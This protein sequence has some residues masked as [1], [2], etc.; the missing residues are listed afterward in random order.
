MTTSF[1]RG[2]WIFAAFWLAACGASAPGSAQTQPPKASRAAGDGLEAAFL[3]K[4]RV[5]E[6][7]LADG[8][9]Y[10]LK[11]KA[12]GT[13]PD[14]VAS[15]KGGLAVEG[16]R[17]AHF[18]VAA[19]LVAEGQERE[20]LLDQ[21][22]KAFEWGFQQAGEDGSFPTERGGTTKKQNSLHPK[23]VFIEAAA[24]SLLLLQ[25]SSIDSR[26]RDRVKALTPAL[27]K[28]A[29]WLAD[30]PD[31][32]AFFQ[33]NRN[34]NQLMVVASA[35]QQ[36]AI[37]TKNPELA[38]KAKALMEKV[39]ARQTA[40]GVFPE[41]GGFDSNY[42][43]VSLDLLGHYY[44]TLEPSDWRNT[45]E[46]ALRKGAE[47][48]VQTVDPATGAINDA[49]NTRTVACGSPVSG[50]GPKGKDIDIVPLRL[51]YL[52]FLLNDEARLSQLAERV[53]GQGQSFSHDDKCPAEKRAKA[54]NSAAE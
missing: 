50:D 54:G 45:V 49:A 30:S 32:V 17:R 44:A 4:P 42:Q 37:V 29:N 6:I 47:R 24:K 9:T 27:L 53:H 20:R 35:L 10:A 33:R 28:S 21:G 22:L 52:G 23:A 31:T 39:L 3:R 2:V 26:T 15:D 41:K 13:F 43:T 40:D 18:I 5:A 48:F 12:D 8:K 25:Q 11:Q 7:Y 51:H 16:L 1:R 19:G 38:V 46:A 34:A 14:T 36:S